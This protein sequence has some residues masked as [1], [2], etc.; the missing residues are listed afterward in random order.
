VMY[1]FRELRDIA[2][3]CRFRDCAH[4]A[5]PG[6]AIIEALENGEVSEERFYSYKRILST[7]TEL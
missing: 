1:G 6:C 2:G 3:H 5:E 4:D 7:L